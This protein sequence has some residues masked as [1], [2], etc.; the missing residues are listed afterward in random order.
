M[1]HLNWILLQVSMGLAGDNRSLLLGNNW[2]YSRVVLLLQTLLG[3][4]LQLQRDHDHSHSTRWPSHVN[5]FN[6][7]PGECLSRSVVSAQSLSL[8]GPLAL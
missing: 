3:R 5:A 4:R 2:P 6:I 7:Y 8:G 1:A